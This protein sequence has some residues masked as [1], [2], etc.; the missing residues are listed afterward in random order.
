MKIRKKSP[1][2][3]S[4]KPPLF[5]VGYRGAPP[6]LDEL[7][8]WYDL[9]YGGPLTCLERDAGG[10]TSASHG[11]WH[12]YLLTSIPESDAAQWQPVLSWD[13]QNLGAVSLSTATPGTIADTVL[14]ASRLARGL[15]LL[16]QGTAFDVT[17]HEYLNPSDWNDRPLNVFFACDH[18]T[19]RQSETDDFSFDW[20]YTLG[21]TKFG[22][23]ELEMIQPRGLPDTETIALLKS[24]ADGLLRVGQNQKVGSSF[25]LPALAQTIRF[26][27][28]RTAAPTGRMMTFRQIITDAN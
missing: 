15:T 20:F 14:V 1:K 25:D 26:I 11:P 18:V 22:L 23:D 5:L 28:H 19:V 21:L 13:H 9:Q 27:K 12:A 7:K 2:P 10:R 24:A 17:C 3:A 6:A 8:I 16:T 4:A